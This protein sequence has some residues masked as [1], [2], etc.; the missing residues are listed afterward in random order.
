MEDFQSH[1]IHLGAF[2]S[3]S[4][5]GAWDGEKRIIEITMRPWAWPPKK[6]KEFMEILFVLDS[7][8]LG[9]AQTYV[10]TLMRQLEEAHYD[11]A[12]A[13]DNGE[14]LERIASTVAIHLLPLDGKNIFKIIRSIINLSH[15]LKA[16][17]VKIVHSNA[18]IPVF[19][20]KIAILISR[21]RI[22][23]VFTVHKIWERDI[24][25]FGKI[26]LPLFYPLIDF[27]VDQV[28]VINLFSNNIFSKK[29]RADKINLIYNG[30]ELGYAREQ[31]VSHQA[32][33]TRRNL[34]FVGRLAPQKRVD[35][36]LKALSHIGKID[37]IKCRIIGDGSLRSSLL[38]LS[39]QLKITDI[40]EFLGYRSDVQR[41]LNDAD[42]FLV[43]SEWEGISY[44]MLEALNTQIPFVGFDVPGVNEMV[45]NNR[46]GLLVLFGDSEG[47]AQAVKRLIDDRELYERLRRGC[48]EILEEKFE[49]H[50]MFKKTVDVY[51]KMIREDH[52]RRA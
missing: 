6:P 1:R 3:R 16:R 42:I 30:I 28:I 38:K 26:L 46:N 49:I 47:L 44:S 34:I 15:L 31:M 51:N 35:L 2:F 50:T 29:I 4:S 41:Y 7:M 14:L 25:V 23:H 33:S 21:R 5:G 22:K 19:I 24:S 45:E 17:E 40:V 48:R 52:G 36:L 11:V 9:G 20:C 32:N 10:I 8:K 27:S 37:N 43:T 18:L 39:A 13:T 12:I